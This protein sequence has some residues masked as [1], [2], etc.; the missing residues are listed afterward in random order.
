MKAFRLAIS[1]VLLL[2]SAA[3]FAQSDAAKSFD[4]LKTL[5]GSW[6]GGVGG[7]PMRANVTLRVTS[8]GNT[9]MHEMKVT[10]RPDDPISMFHLDNGHLQMTHYCDAGNQ[11]HFV[12]TVSPDGK[13][14]TFDYVDATNLHAG[15]GGH[16]QH[17]I[18]TILDA[19]HHTELWQFAG[20][21]GKVMGAL[22]DLKRVK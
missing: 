8:M 14:F 10:G 21:D 3:A 5:A 4:Q 18:F 9:L 20:E 6:E 19:D 15:Q 16:M 1:T 11:P 22:M 17:V 12:A 7:M 2:F 13:T